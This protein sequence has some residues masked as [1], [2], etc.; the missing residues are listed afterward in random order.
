MTASHVVL[1][2]G[3]NDPMIHGRRV[4]AGQILVDP[5]GR[6][7][8]GI[9]NHPHMMPRTIEALEVVI[10]PNDSVRE[11]VAVD[12]MAVMQGDTLPA[13]LLD[14]TMKAELGMGSTPRHGL[15]RVQ[16]GLINV[17]HLGSMFH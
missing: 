15:P 2:L 13:C 4:K 10:S 5:N 6:R 8:T 1:D 3:A 7:I 9:T 17:T 11:A 14:N 16:A 12:S